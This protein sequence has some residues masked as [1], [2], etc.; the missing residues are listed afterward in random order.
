MSII[1]LLFKDHLSILIFPYPSE[2]YSM[3]LHYLK[4][5]IF[6]LLTILVIISI[7]L[8]GAWIPLGFFLFSAIIVLGDA[9]FGDD[10]SIPDFKHPSVFSLQ[11]YAA[12]PLLLVLMFFSLW[13]IS[14]DDYLNVGAYL[15][16]IFNY[17]FL[18]ARANTQDWQHVVS[19]FFVGL[20]VST[21]GTVTAHELVHKT[22]NKTAVCAGRWLL[23][24]SFDANFSIEHV[25]GHHKNIGTLD[26]PATAPRG[27]NVYAH[28]VIST[29][30]GNQSAWKIES[31]RL[32]NRGLSTFSIYNQ[33]IRGYLM[34]ILL[35]VVAY[36]IG[37]ITALAYF[38]AVAIVAKG[39]LEIVNYMEHYGLVKVAKKR[40]EPR[41]SWNTNKKLSSWAL[42]NL[43]RHSHH[44]AQGQMP[45]HRLQPYNKAPQMI[46]GYLATML[47][48]LI[49]PLWFHLMESKLKEW[50]NHYASAEEQ[51]IIKGSEGI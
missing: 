47:L 3:I 11:L 41:H 8:G 7:V 26:D 1:T 20:M 5:S 42:F 4:F 43:S 10:L 29:I 34:S 45:F 17:D 28:M 51:A 16:Q 25:Y 19:V 35:L 39:M 2:S 9:W 27:R 31:R 44:H 30:K 24:F 40:V 49:P 38:V 50:D 23:A 15:S 22:W 12:I 46:T 36:L 48:T 37:G 32:S 14:S 6:H 13:S 18:L 33:C 21:V